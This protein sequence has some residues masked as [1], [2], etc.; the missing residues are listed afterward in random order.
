MKLIIPMAGRGTRVRPHSHVTPKPLLNVRGTS[1]VE[2]IVDTFNAVLPRPLD[3]GV[4]ILGPDFG[5]AVR[6]TL[7]GICERHGMTASFA[8]QDPPL[9]TA[10]AVGV[11]GDALEGEGIVVFADTLFYMEPGVSLDEADVV[12]W[13]K[14]VDDPRRFGVAVR[15]GD[16]VVEFVEKPDTI[17]SNEA[18][19]GIY[20][21]KDLA[22]MKQGIDYLFENKIHGK[23]GEYY[24]TDAFDWMLKQGDLFRTANVTEWLDCGTIPALKDTTR[25]VLDYEK[26]KPGGGEALN[27]TVIE[28]VFLAEGARV[29]NSV[30]GPNVSVEAGAVVRDSV[31]TNSILFA[32]AVVEHARLDDSL[33]GQNAEVR[34]FSGSAN[35]GDHSTIG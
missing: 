17:I 8:V 6:D 2:R 21:V 31:V 34:G 13:V 15:E 18:L 11:A 1:M 25:F 30:V 28:P 9:G 4:F 7:T 19:I 14:H 12:A 32:N 16:R 22:R 24:L 29:E 26:E 3:S 23:G 33:V 20:Y 27:S 10:H 5:D 35:V